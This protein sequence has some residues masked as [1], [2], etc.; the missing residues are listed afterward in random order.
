MQTLLQDTIELVTIGADRHPT[1][2]TLTEFQRERL[3]AAAIRDLPAA[4]KFDPIEAVATNPSFIDK[5]T[6]AL[7]EQNMLDRNV[8][9]KEL[10][11]MLLQCAVKHCESDIT[12]ALDKAQIGLSLGRQF[13]YNHEEELVYLD[14]RERARDM[15]LARLGR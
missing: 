2:N 5:I 15:N 14:N 6:E 8:L 9:L 10:G 3:T 1:Y 4:W 7:E 13:N 11:E 12:D